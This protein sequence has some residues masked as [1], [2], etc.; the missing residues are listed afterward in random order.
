MDFRHFF[1][2]P[3]DDS[4]KEANTRATVEYCLKNPQ[5]KLSLQTHKLVGIP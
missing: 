2:Q 3:L 5:W 4:R 1:L